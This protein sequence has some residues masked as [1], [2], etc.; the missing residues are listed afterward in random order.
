MPSTQQVQE[1]QLK[2]RPA[3]QG[4]HCVDRGEP[5]RVKRKDCDV[6]RLTNSNAPDSNRAITV[7]I[8]PNKAAKL[9]DPPFSASTVLKPGESLNWNVKSQISGEVIVRYR[10]DPDDCHGADQD[11]IVIGE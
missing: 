2:T 9:F 7:F 3:G 4:S 5:I 11:D 6:V 8:D 10:T 1:R